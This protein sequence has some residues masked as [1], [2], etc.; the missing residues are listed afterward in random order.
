MTHCFKHGAVTI[1][2]SVTMHCWWVK[3]CWHYEGMC[4]HLEG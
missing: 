2:S 4:L 3:V 1:Q